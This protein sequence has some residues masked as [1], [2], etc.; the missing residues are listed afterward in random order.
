M[1]VISILLSSLSGL[2]LFSTLICGLW[3]RSHGVT[4]DGVQFHVNI[5][6]LAVISSAAT[7]ITLLVMSLRK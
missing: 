7:I 1:N 4:P 6:I 3:L 5:A 2:F